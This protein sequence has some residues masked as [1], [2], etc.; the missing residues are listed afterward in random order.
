MSQPT[1]VSRVGVIFLSVAIGCLAV[2]AVLGAVNH[3]KIGL[4]AGGMGFAAIAQL[5]R[6]LRKSR[7]GT[8]PD[9]STAPEQS[10]TN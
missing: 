2:A 7:V 10:E 9:Q 6:M 4:V 1:S 5:T 8:E 3:E